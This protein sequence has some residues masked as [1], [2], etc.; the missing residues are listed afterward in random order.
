MGKIT[1]LEK[2]RLL[3]LFNDLEEDV[4][5][6]LFQFEKREDGDSESMLYSFD[7][8]LCFSDARDIRDTIVNKISQ[9]EQL[10]ISD[11]T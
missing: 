9:I 3:K 11:A 10:E 6:R 1:Q 2:Q 7:Y 8:V 5:K 4:E